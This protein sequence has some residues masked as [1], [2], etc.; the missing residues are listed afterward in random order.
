MRAAFWRN[1]GIPVFWSY[2][3]GSVKAAANTMV[4]INVATTIHC[5]A[6][7]LIHFPP[8]GLMCYSG[9]SA[10]DKVLV[11]E[12]VMIQLASE[13]KIINKLDWI[14]LK[15][16]YVEVGIFTEKSQHFG[17]FFNKVLNF[18]FFT[19]KPKILGKVFKLVLFTSCSSPG[20]RSM[21]SLDLDLMN[22]LPDLT[23]S[24]SQ[25]NLADSD[26]LAI[27]LSPDSNGNPFP[28]A[29]L[30]DNSQFESSVYT[31]S[32]NR[33][34]KL[35]RKPIHLNHWHRSQHFDHFFNKVLSFFLLKN[36]KYWVKF[37]YWSCLPLV[38]GKQDQFEN[39]THTPSTSIVVPNEKKNYR[40]LVLDQVDS[41]AENTAG[42]V[43]AEKLEQRYGL[44]AVVVA[45][46]V[47]VAL[48]HPASPVPA[49]GLRD[50]VHLVELTG[51]K[52]VNV[53]KSRAL[54]RS[55]QRVTSKTKE[56]KKNRN[57]TAEGRPVEQ[58]RTEEMHRGRRRPETLVDMGISV[59]VVLRLRTESHYK[60][61]WYGGDA[62]VGDDEIIERFT[63][64]EMAKTEV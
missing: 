36:P 47:A 48:V 10:R 55:G 42:V 14:I 31:D 53:Y 28:K 61:G 19:K 58:Q 37:S 32:I 20:A 4:A 44:A 24:V 63:K 29:E 59:S 9:S 40:Q 23:N 2:P 46:V 64:R 7:S 60:Y 54:M 11:W 21:S 52:E 22:V 27:K 16:L 8:S 3:P 13:V 5:E 25:S 50:L 57:E 51:P 45:V 43:V 30:I 39:F 56:T 18:F 38:A 15:R 34:A 62:H 41:L 35:T 6:V 26:S 33:V 12:E 1:I 17:H 49:G